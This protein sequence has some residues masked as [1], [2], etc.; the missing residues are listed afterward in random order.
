MHWPLASVTNVR[1]SPVWVLVSDDGHAR[2][3]GTL[4]VRDAPRER[5]EAFLCCCEAG[6]GQRERQQERTYA[7]VHLLFSPWNQFERSLLATFATKRRT[8]SDL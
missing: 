7:C 8:K 6:Q 3:G 4:L 2:D 1:T 5:A